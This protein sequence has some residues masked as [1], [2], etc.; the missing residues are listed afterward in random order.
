MHGY[1]LVELSS[2]AV[3][4]C[5]VLI[6]A[7][8]VW[9]YPAV[10]LPRLLI[11]AV[12]RDDPSPP[13]Q[14]PFVLS[15]TGVRGIVSLAA[16]LAIPFTIANGELFPQRDLI[17]FITFV[18]I[19]VTLVIQGA[20]LPFVIQSLGLADAGRSEHA[21][22][23]RQE[24]EARL[25]AVEAALERLDQLGRERALSDEVLR[26]I[27]ALHRERLQ[28]VRH[29]ADGDDGHR[30]LTALREEIEATLIAA[31]RQRVNQLY[32][33]GKLIDETRR[34]IELELDLREAQA[35]NRKSDE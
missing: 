29:H 26:P 3:I 9:I 16:A 17:L 25:E 31:E 6:A 23:R 28:H 14:W 20:M 18:V 7:R 13:W 2:S 22:D 30:R 1:S 5:A 12:R 34:K 10:Y 15:F 11:P 8:F 24:H 4:V 33:K 32:R 19:L 21:R 27:R 35:A